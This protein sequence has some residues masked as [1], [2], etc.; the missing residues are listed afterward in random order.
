M[1]PALVLLVLAGCTG[2]QTGEITELSLCERVVE[3]VPLADL[4]MHTREALDSAT[5][6]HETAL[7]WSDGAATVVVADPELATATAD[8]LGP[9]PCQPVVRV[10]VAIPIST[11]D[12]RIDL[13]VHGLAD[14]AGDVVTMQGG[15]HVTSLN[16]RDQLEAETEVWLWI[17]QTADSFGGELSLDGI[18][19]AAF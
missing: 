10:P 18:P 19:V 3:R 9:H 12:G 4:P 13:V 15:A 1:R 16:G 6:R 5:A 2:G 17:E 11:A 7:T 8:R 14:V